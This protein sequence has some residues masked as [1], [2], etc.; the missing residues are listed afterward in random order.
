MECQIPG[1]F[2]SSRVNES[3]QAK[4]SR[5][6]PA[7]SRQFQKL[8]TS[9]LLPRPRGNEFIINTK[10]PVCQENIFHLNMYIDTGLPWLVLKLR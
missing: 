4:S 10:C 7:P 2:G 8:R 6:F 3:P 9:L 1:H 5:R